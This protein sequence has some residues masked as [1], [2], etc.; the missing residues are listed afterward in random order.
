ML[1]MGLG[2]ATANLALP[3]GSS[4]APLSRLLGLLRDALAEFSV[5][6]PV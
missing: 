2:A 1:G 3:A 5:A 6:M 4:R